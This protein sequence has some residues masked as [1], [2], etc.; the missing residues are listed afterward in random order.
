VCIKKELINNIIKQIE[1]NNKRNESRKYFTKIQKLK[2]QNTRLPYMCKD[3]NNIVISQMN[4]ILT[5]WKEYFCT[6][7]KSDTE[8][9]LSYHRIQSTAFDN[10]TD[11]EVLFSSYN[12]ACLIN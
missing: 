10:Q 6:I 8:D 9:S 7:L 5:R 11:T 2:W 3:V 12:E 1:E 4:Q